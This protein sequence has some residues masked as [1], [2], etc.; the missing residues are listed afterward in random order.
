MLVQYENAQI[1]YEH[2]CLDQCSGCRQDYVQETMMIG[3][4]YHDYAQTE[5]ASYK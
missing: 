4:Q 1:S 2:V 5:C 3:R